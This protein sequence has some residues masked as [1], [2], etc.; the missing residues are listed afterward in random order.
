MIPK[1]GII[2]FCKFIFVKL[3]NTPKKFP[4]QPAYY[5]KSQYN[6]K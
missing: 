4:E 3:Q 6:R 1:I 5:V 2:A